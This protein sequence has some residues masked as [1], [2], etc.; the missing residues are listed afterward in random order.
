MSPFLIFLAGLALG[1]LIGA[2]LRRPSLSGRVAPPPAPTA[3]PD[4][5]QEKPLPAPA[6]VAEPPPAAP[7][8]PRSLAELARELESFYE[9]S[10]HPSELAANATFLAGVAQLSDPSVAVEH[11]AN[12]QTGANKELAAIAGAALTQRTDSAAVLSRVLGSYRFAYVW[13]NFYSL[14]YLVAHANVPVVGIVLARAPEWWT[15]NAVMPQLLSDFI[16]ARI[17][18]GE[19]LDLIGALNAEPHEDTSSLEA[20][21]GKLATPHARTLREQLAKW[22]GTRVDRKF[23]ASVGK[24]RAPRATPPIEHAY[25]LT[26]V[27]VGLEAINQSPP[28]SFV[29]TGEPGAGKSALFDVIATRLAHAG[30]TIFEASASD[31]GAGMSYIGELEGRMRRLLDEIDVRR[32]VVWYVPNIH[33]LFYAGRHRMN[34]TGILDMILP[35]VEAGRIVVIG[36]A[37]PTALERVVQQRPRMRGAFASL[38]LE[39]LEADAAIPLA[40]AFLAR[41][42]AGAGITAGSEVVREALELARHYLGSRVLPGSVLD[43]L[44]L[45]IARMA[46]GGTAGATTTIVRAD[47]LATLIE[48]TGLPMSVLDERAGL[49]PS[50]LRA[51]FAKRVM[52]QPEAVECLVD[53]VAMLKAGLTDPHRPLGVFLFA[54]PTG[55]GKTEVAK[56]LATYLFGSAARMIRLDMSEFQEPASM[57]RIL[58]E[59]DATSEATALTQRIRK[60]PFSVVLLD[61]FEKA[62]PRVWD[63]FLQVFD[64]GRL[65]DA[66]GA[67]ADF[68]HS[69][70]ILTSNLGATAHQGSSLGFNDSASPFSATQ[71]T[72]AIAQTFR[73]EF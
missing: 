38:A 64:D 10:A 59:P 55:T 13:T 40:E 71:V 37:S 31:V 6:P 68:R 26:G 58:G 69:I 21:L 72:R 49:D 36:E 70:I 32:R 27:S 18:A 19:A 30:W 23:L 42:A 9:S 62:H 29:I 47:L 61:E 4:A 24:L 52:G 17:G 14:Q 11:V 66:Q 15:E 25:L 73:P 5:A 28:R 45:T 35:A 51:Y 20:L 7:A 48:L 39:P 22:K 65:T 54:G 63:L 2:V 67:T 16:D 41:E 8:P 56:T 34:P 44:R 12:Y 60:Q 57:M 43:L 53:R 3:A 50:A 46:K 1:V 33:E